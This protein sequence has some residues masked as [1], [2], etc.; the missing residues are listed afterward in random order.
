MT[1]FTSLR[2]EQEG[3]LV[4]ITLNRPHALNALDIGLFNEL[5]RALIEAQRD[6]DIQIPIITGAGRAFCAGA[7]VKS[8]AAHHA[9]EQERWD[10]AYQYA[11]AANA[12]FSQIAQMDKIVI[13]AVNG[14]AHAA[15]I[16]LAAS[17]DIAIASQKASFR[18]PEGL[19]GIAD[20]LST[21]WLRASVGLARARYLIFTAATISADEA[22]G[23]GLI[24]KAVPHEALLPTV[25]EAAD[26][27]MRT[28]PRARTVFKHLLNKELP[29]IELRHIV[30]SHLS[31]ESRDGAKAFAAKRPPPWAKSS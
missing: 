10:G 6:P 26:A 15:G 30:D 14:L 22:V 3:P 16:V 4:F 25:R 29:K 17:C 1:R 13:A 8:V 21:V 28:G 20:E 23:M 27:A 11:E 7:D 31:E 9:S 5:R 19:V 24:S 12:L 18:V 2:Y